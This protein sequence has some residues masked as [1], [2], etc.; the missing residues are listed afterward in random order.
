MYGATGDAKTVFRRSFPCS[1]H[2]HREES[3]PQIA[4]LSPPKPVNSHT[5]YC[6]DGRYV[7]H[8]GPPGRLPPRMRAT[9][10]D[11]RAPQLQMIDK[12]H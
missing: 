3:I 2:P 9:R 4:L 5:G 7:Q 1:T 10:Y 12:V 8:H 6:Q 11:S